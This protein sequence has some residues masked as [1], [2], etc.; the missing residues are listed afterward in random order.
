MKGDLIFFNI[1]QKKE[2]KIER[3]KESIKEKDKDM[4]KE[5]SI[6]IWK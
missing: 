2:N 1:E 5:K 4:D 6:I 3:T